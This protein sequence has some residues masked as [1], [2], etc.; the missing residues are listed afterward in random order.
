M[1]TNIKLNDS[2]FTCFLDSMS[3]RETCD[4]NKLNPSSLL[5]PPTMHEKAL[6][7]SKK[8]ALKT[9]FHAGAAHMLKL[10]KYHAKRLHEK[11]KPEDSQV[12]IAIRFFGRLLSCSTLCR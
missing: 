12:H 1:P 8:K 7:Y 9:I 4:T 5:K 2:E 10:N 6:E 3:S 11:G